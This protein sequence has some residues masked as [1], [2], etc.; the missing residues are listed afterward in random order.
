MRGQEEAPP[1][2]A[3]PLPASDARGYAA[4]MASERVYGARY[5]VGSPRLADAGV[6]LPC[7][8]SAMFDVELTPE[9]AHALGGELLTAALRAGY[10]PPAAKL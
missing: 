7:S 6:V 5:K 4:P 1:L 8:D 10:R 9:E 3:W 2:A